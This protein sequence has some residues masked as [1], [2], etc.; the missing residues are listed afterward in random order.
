[1]ADKNTT[2]YHLLRG[3]DD[4]PPITYGWMWF[5]WMWERLVR[6]EWFG[7]FLWYHC[8]DDMDVMV[9]TLSPLALRDAIYEYAKERK[10][11]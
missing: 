10:M 9:E 3:L 2:V 11:I 6:K 8:C 1:M 4:G 7:A 5:G